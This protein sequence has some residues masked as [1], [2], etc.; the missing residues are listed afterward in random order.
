[1]PEEKATIIIAA[2]F[3]RLHTNKALRKRFKR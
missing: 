2:F 3:W 1:M